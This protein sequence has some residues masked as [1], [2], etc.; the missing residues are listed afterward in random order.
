MVCVGLWLKQKLVMMFFKQDPSINHLEQRVADMF[1]MQR[2]MF[3]PSGTMSNQVAVG[4]HTNPGD[5]LI[6]DRHTHIYHYE[7]GGAAANWGVSCRL[8]EGNR[9]RLTATQVKKK[10]QIR[11]N[12]IIRLNKLVV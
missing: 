1:G 12:L 2:G 4:L 7:G 10:Y 8:V 6:C 3:F 9:G 11:V 5:Q